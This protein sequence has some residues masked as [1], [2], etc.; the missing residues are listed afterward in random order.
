[1][2]TPIY[3]AL[4][5]ILFLFLSFKTIKVRKRLQIGVGTG[6]NPEL[7]RA[8]R[9]HANFSEYVPIT[10]I[11]ILSVELLKGHFILVHGLGVALLIGR[12]LHA[13]GVS[14]TKENL[15]F[16]V[17]GM[18]LTFSTMLVSIVSIIYLSIF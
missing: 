10:L 6:D 15:K 4:L 18:L 14:Q 5:A 17:S 2:I 3:V 11:L 7:L 8:M 1:M 16:R 13:Y 12:V 9:V